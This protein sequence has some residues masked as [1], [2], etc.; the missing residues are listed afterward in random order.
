MTNKRRAGRLAQWITPWLLASALAT[1]CANAP[2]SDGANNATSD[3][4]DSGDDNSPLD[5]TSDTGS[6]APPQPGT[7]CGPCK[8]D[9]SCGASL[10][11]STPANVCKTAK[12]LQAPNLPVCAADC[13]I[14]AMCPTASACTLVDG[15]CVAVSSPEG[16][17]GGTSDGQDD[18]SSACDCALHK[19]KCAFLPGCTLS[20]GQCSNG[21]LCVDNQ[22]VSP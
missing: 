16:D 12:E 13:L 2:A 18:V 7:H 9:G 10:A 5:G 14:K 4:V 21:F 1:A 3:V 6:S 11:C 22:C 17:A 8:K 15:K 19:A 20:C